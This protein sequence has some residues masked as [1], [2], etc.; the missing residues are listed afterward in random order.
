MHA[1]DRYQLARCAAVLCWQM[2]FHAQDDNLSSACPAP[3]IATIQRN[4]EH[5][6]GQFR[7]DHSS[8]LKP[9][10]SCESGVSTAA[11]I[12]PY[13]YRALAP[14]GHRCHSVE[15]SLAD[16]GAEYTQQHSTII[17]L[18]AATFTAPQNICTDKREFSQLSACVRLCMYCTSGSRPP[19]YAEISHRPASPATLHCN[20]T[21]R[22]AGTATLPALRPCTALT[23][24]VNRTTSRLCRSDR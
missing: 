3:S 1:A 7:I 24:H 10:P 20:R 2:M 19:P 13:L 12:R 16:A 8:T 9:S 22:A 23:S 11:T 14:R 6:R 4:A 18:C 21:H 15:R 5:A 17:T